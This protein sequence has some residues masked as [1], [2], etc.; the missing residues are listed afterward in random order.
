[1]LNLAIRMPRI[2]LFFLLLLQSWG[3]SQKEFNLVKSSENI[4]VLDGFISSAEKK[5]FTCF[6]NKL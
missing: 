4:I 6:P 2:L 5:K 1:M 3:Y